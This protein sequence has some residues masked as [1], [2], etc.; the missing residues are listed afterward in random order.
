MS[1]ARI[2]TDIWTTKQGMNISD[3]KQNDLGIDLQ[4]ETAS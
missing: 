4:V 2:Y 3:W 1:M